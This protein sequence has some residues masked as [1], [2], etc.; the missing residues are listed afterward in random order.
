MELLLEQTQQGTSHEVSYCQNIR[1]I[2]KYHGEDGN[3]ARVNIKQALSS[4]QD[5]ERYE[6]VSPQDTRPQDGDRSQDD[7]QRLD[8]ADDLKKAQDHIS[9]T[10]SSHKIKS[11]TSKYKTSHEESKTTS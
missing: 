7:D 2:L 5:Q 8:L 1:V 11:T 6:H 4:F 9:S 3:P 10:N